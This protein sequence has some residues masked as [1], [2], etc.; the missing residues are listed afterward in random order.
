MTYAGMGRGGV[1][2]ELL[3]KVGGQG[4]AGGAAA[5]AKSIAQSAKQGAKALA[6]GAANIA[7]NPV[8][9]AQMLRQ[10][11]GAE[12]ALSYQPKTKAEERS[13]RLVSR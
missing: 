6:T 9:Q 13:G 1:A 12:E 5:K 11:T 3:S 10:A 4:L 8:V 2:E 7:K